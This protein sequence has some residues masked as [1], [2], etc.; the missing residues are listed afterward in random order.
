VKLLLDELYSQEI[1]EQLRVRGHDVTAVAER[2]DLRGLPDEQL[3]N[4]AAADR[5]ALVTENWRHFSA[6]VT[7]AAHEGAN[8]Y[9]VVFTSGRQMP[10]GRGTI[11][12]FVGIFD[13]FLRANPNADAL[14][15]GVRW[16]P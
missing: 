4:Y 10:R 5:R 8:H 9:G 7:Q 13:E 12:L 1:A 6:L 3:F 2:V 14:A 16:R 11:G 15:N